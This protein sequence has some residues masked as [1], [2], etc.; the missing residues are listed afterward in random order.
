MSLAIA[1]SL[2]P[3]AQAADVAGPRP[4]LKAGTYGPGCSSV[5]RCG[6]RGCAWHAVCP[7]GCPDGYS[8]YPLYG[9]YGPYG[10]A[11]YWGAYTDSGWGR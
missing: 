7:R 5:Y 6:P 8:C 1:L 3:I 2:G 11:A 4:V 10:G 9:A